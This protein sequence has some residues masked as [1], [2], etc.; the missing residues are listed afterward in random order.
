[1]YKK[2]NIFLIFLFI[3]IALLLAVITLIFNI[4]TIWIDIVMFS[5]AGV[6]LIASGV[7]IFFLIQQ[8]MRDKKLQNDVMKFISPLKESYG[9]EIYT[10][11][12]VFPYYHKTLRKK[13]NLFVSFDKNVDGAITMIISITHNHNFNLR[14]TKDIAYNMLGDK[15]FEGYSAKYEEDSVVRKIKQRIRGH[16]NISRFLN[17]KDRLAILEKLLNANFEIDFD[18]F[19]INL[20]LNPVNIKDNYYLFRGVE[21]IIDLIG[22]DGLIMENIQT[23]E[24]THEEMTKPKKSQH[25]NKKS[26]YQDKEVE[27]ILYYGP[28]VSLIGMVND[29][30]M[31]I[32]KKKINFNVPPN[33]NNTY[34]ISALDREIYSN[35]TGKYIPIGSIVKAFIKSNP[36]KDKLG[37]EDNKSKDEGHKVNI[38]TNKSK[39]NIMDNFCG[40]SLKELLIGLLSPFYSG[41]HSHN[42]KYQL[43]SPFVSVLRYAFT[44]PKN[45][46]FAFRT[47]DGKKCHELVFYAKSN[48]TRDIYAI[49]KSFTPAKDIG[50]TV[51]IKWNMLYPVN[52]RKYIKHKFINSVDK[53]NQ[54]IVDGL[55]LLNKKQQKE[56]AGKKEKALSPIRTDKVK[57]HKFILNL[58]S[59]ENKKR[60]KLYSQGVLIR[61][62][63]DTPWDIKIDLPD[64][65][66][67]VKDMSDFNRT[68]RYNELINEFFDFLT[69][70]LINANI[71]LKEILDGLAY[72][73]DELVED[74]YVIKKSLKKIK[75]KLVPKKEYYCRME[76]YEIFK[77]FFDKDT[78]DKILPIISDST[79]S[80]WSSLFMSGEDLLSKK[81]SL[82]DKD[83]KKQD[84]KK[85]DYFNR[86]PEEHQ[87]L[88]AYYINKA[89]FKGRICISENKAE[90]LS[91]FCSLDGNLYIN[92]SAPILNKNSEDSLFKYTIITTLLKSLGYNEKE[93]EREVML[94]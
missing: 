70:R 3:I 10:E 25:K 31:F 75:E 33:A 19:N 77:S 17:S 30:R 51:K 92:I 73:A 34:L 83:I 20:K 14:L 84:L 76:N 35:F 66:D 12:S 72:L 68:P 89:P 48:K 93:I 26:S 4:N 7:F 47:S 37:L 13:N 40:L 11:N 28:L 45:F 50:S 62:L 74:T 87:K 59:D 82:L 88:I 81:L 21:A 23:I 79:I 58:E 36:Q 90:G 69:T 67:L 78:S 42:L 5:L 94:C 64:S 43:Y 8:L 86:L 63:N 38:S 54:I 46:R 91:P 9:G 61:Q 57:G 39:I 32:G 55:N 15:L 85:N 27:E 71:E 80:L 29:S 6:S 65:V 56:P 22:L 24:E 41:S 44:D 18:Y 2:K 1:M 16:K 49:V 52:I 60:L 53:H